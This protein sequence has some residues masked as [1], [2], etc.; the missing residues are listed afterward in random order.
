MTFLNSIYLA[1]LSAIV[2][3]LLIHFLSRRRIKIIDFSSLKFLFQMQKTRLRWLRIREILLLLLRILILAFLALAFARPALT[4]K[5]GSSHAPTSAVLLIDNSPSSERLSSSGI[6]YDDIKKG[7]LQILS[8][9]GPSDEISFITLSGKP[10]TYGPFSDLVRAKDALYATAPGAAGPSVREG[11]KQAQEILA[12]S[13]N[14]N[15]DIY[16]LSDMQ[17]GP[18]WQSLPGNAV[19]SS[20]NYYVIGY[21]EDDF[22]N[23]GISS[24]QFP[25]QLLAPGEDFSISANLKNYSDKMI[26]GRV[27]ELYLDNVKKAQTAVDIKTQ[28]NTSIDF[29]VAATGPGFH[30]GYIEIE[31]DDYSPDNKFY[32]DFTIPS[33]ISV[34]AIGQ[35]PE[36]IQPLDNC[37]GDNK[38]GYINY[39]GIS[40]GEFSR[41][42]LRSF[43][44]VILSNITTLPAP[45][46]NSLQDF[47]NNGGGLFI[48]IG[49]NG[50]PDTYRDFL[51]SYAGINLTKRIS[52]GDNNSGQNYF[53]LKDFD[54][55]NPIF[56]IYAGKNQESLEIPDLKIRSFVE[57][58]GGAVLGMLADKRA[59]I[60][61]S[62]TNKIVFFG[63]GFDIASS[64][65]ARHSFFVPF[66]VRTI[67]YLAAKSTAG[68]EFY[69]A[70][71][72]ASISLI[73]QTQAVSARLV[74]PSCDLT[75]PV[76]R[77]AYGPF[78]NIAE[79]GYPGFYTLLGGS[80]T[81]GYL[82]ANPDS[83]ESTDQKI[84][85]NRL[86]EIF[87]K[88]LAYLDSKSDIK[89]EIV[90][91]KFGL[92]LW[93]Y[94][95]ALALICLIVES[96]LV[97]EPK[98][99]PL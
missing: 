36:D 71:K 74:G 32:F 84:D 83:S 70:G 45:Y 31:D 38:V 42:N 75:L 46:I 68:Q 98:Q 35:T 6:L 21:T 77:G 11:I 66:V 58:S 99:K 22:D 54:L 25:P 41:Q 92:E 96:I 14:L 30:R 63:S 24:I 27:A 29:S 86:K 61:Q 16:I 85:N 87:G 73:N 76:A 57:S 1:A 19:D 5:H 56:K 10:A 79:I 9:L 90:Q 8:L 97:R 59:I 94:C 55:T 50:L 12:A 18:E 34:L 52:A 3:P 43:N 60:S 20:Y 4:G 13:K 64:D 67:E 48:A 91:A 40:L 44:V 37:L 81:L 7:A 72:P 26:N 89:T 93:K 80:D 65:I 95:L 23:A 39:T 78:V 47:L 2:I 88:N 28:A 53:D 15:R 33:A 51:N 62:S 69:F 17:S 82:A 49:G